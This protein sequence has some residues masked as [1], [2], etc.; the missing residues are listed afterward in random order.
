MT[1]KP[2]QGLEIMKVR[3]PTLDFS[4]ALPHWCVDPIFGAMWNASS[5]MLP[6]LE[7]FMNRVVSK[8]RKDL[9]GTDPDTMALKEELAVFISQEGNHYQIHESYN[10]ILRARPQK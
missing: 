7:P 9:T 10:A 6:T 5:M 2:L 3:R 4:E 8:V 1:K